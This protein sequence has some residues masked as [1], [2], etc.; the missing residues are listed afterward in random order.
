MSLSSKGNVVFVKTK[1][2]VLVNQSGLVARKIGDLVDV[3]TTGKVDG[4]ILIYDETIEKFKAS[5]LLEKQIVNGG[6]F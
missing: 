5:T 3:D 6:N 4:S 1:P 2:T